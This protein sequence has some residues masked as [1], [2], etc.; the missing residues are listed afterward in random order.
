MTLSI[1]LEN[2]KK[3]FDHAVNS[4]S[5]KTKRNKGNQRGASFISVIFYC[6]DKNV[7]VTLTVLLID[8]SE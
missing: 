5:N 1:S 6:F 8:C 3:S 4:S 7:F 2:G